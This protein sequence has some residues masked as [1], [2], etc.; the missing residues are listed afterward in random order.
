MALPLKPNN[1]N[2][3]IPNNPFSAPLNPYLQGPYFPFV[4]GSGIDLNTP[5]IPTITN[6]V[7]A[8]LSAGSG[9]SLSTTGGITTITAT[10]GGG[11]SGTVTSVL[12]GTGLTGGPITTSGTIALATS[13]ATA[14][15]YTNANVTVDIYGRI[16]TVAN[17]SAGGTGTVTSVSTGTG[18]TGGP[19]TTTGTIALAN[20]AVSAGAYTYGSFTVDAQGRLTAASSGTAP[21]TAVTGTAPISVTAGLTPVVSIAAAS[22]TASG[23]VQLNNTTANTSTSLALTAAQ[24]KNLQ[25]QIDAL[26]I[27]SN[28]TLAG[29]LDTVTGNLVTVTTAGTTAGFAVGSPLPAAAVG[30]AEHFVIVTVAAT[31]Y[32]PPGGAATLTHVGDWFLSSG[33][34]WD[35][36]DVGFDPQYASTTTPGVVQ[37][38]TNVQTQTG[39]DA[40][41]AVTPAGAAATYI[42]LADYATKGDI[43]AATGA[44]TPIALPVGTD[45][46]ILYANSACSAGLEWGVR[47]ITCLDFDAKGD[48][49]VGAAPDSFATLGVGTDG[50]ALLACS[51]ATNGVCW[52]T[53]TAAEATPTTLGTLK[54]CAF[55]SY[56]ALGCNAAVARTTGSLNVAIGVG[57]LCSA[58]TASINIA[59][60]NCALKSMVSINNNI[61]IGL[62][63]MCAAT[64]GAQNIAL[65]NQTMTGAIGANNLAIGNQAMRSATGSTSVAIGNNALFT[66]SGTENVAVGYGAGFT[67]AAGSSNTFVGFGA[68]QTVTAGSCNTFLGA[69]ADDNADVSCCLIVGANTLRWLTGDNTGAIKPAAGVID[70]VNSCG[71]AG[72]VLMSNGSNAICWGSAGGSSATPITEGVVFGCTTNGGTT[73]VSLGYGAGQNDVADC[74]TW[75]GTSAGINH[76]TGLGNTTLG[77][78]SA[79]NLISGV[80]NIAIGVQALQ[81]T[82]A[83]AGTPVNANVAIGNA[84]LFNT[85]GCFNT[86]VGMAAGFSQSAGSYNVLLGYFASAPNPSGSGQLAIGNGPTSNWLT[87]DVNYAIKPGAG[88]IDCAASTGTAGQVLMSNGSNAICWGAAG[89]ASAATPTVAGVVKGFIN[90]TNTALGCNAA[91]VLAATGLSNTAIGNCAG[92]ALDD[93]CCNTLVGTSAGCALNF[94]LGHTVIGT[95][96]GAAITTGFYNVFVGTEAGASATQDR[97]VFIGACA[98]CAQTTGRSNVAIGDGVNVPITTG[99]CQLAIGYSSAFTCWLTGNNTG[100]IKPGAG[101]IDCANSCGTVGQYLWTTGANRIIWSASSPSDTRDKEVLG[102]VPTALPVVQQIEPITYRWKERDSD[103]A[104]E[105]VI[106]GF[107]AQQLQEVDSVLVDNSDPGHLRIHDRKIVPLLVNAIKELSAKVE[108]LEAKL[109]ANG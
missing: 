22:T 47:P 41:L 67:N 54:G 4:A 11:G 63:S 77:W 109:E 57:A 108:A 49:L 71:T 7:A 50:Q 79:S 90:A 82:G 10:G 68:G 73:P 52:G 3:P 97:N 86:A 103:V 85:V 21:V 29:T 43:L 53:A 31:S 14:G 78:C 72:Q 65:G 75:I 99:G 17:G 8:V 56:V 55:S 93:A 76:T 40:T 91:A 34:V 12:T 100:A 95:G 92:F 20:T 102:P 96:A 64:S 66:N 45:G 106:Y 9:I 26:A 37:L 25:D 18:L 30:N 87:G 44:S 81:V 105:E 16:T 19:V 74:N 89:G 98:G 59:I 69:C 27:T 88:I 1:P 13:G 23:A 42:P 15:S 80:D 5:G 84:S 70:C 107:S 24:G 51:T 46:Q 94:G 32:T 6:D 38:A 39:T 33:T 48:L 62:S 83:T 60:G 58:T 61:A 35:F 104:Q 28:L 101:I 36:L 2:I